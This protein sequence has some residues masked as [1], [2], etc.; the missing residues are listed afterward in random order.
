MNNNESNEDYIVYICIGVF[1]SGA[2][3]SIMA[4]F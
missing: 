3:V 1:I 4:L 2:I